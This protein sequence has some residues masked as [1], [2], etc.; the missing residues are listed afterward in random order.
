MPLALI[1][2]LDFKKT[3]TTRD[4]PDANTFFPY[5]DDCGIDIKDISLFLAYNGFD[6][7]CSIKYPGNTFKDGLK[8]LY[9]HL[10]KAR[11]LSDS[12]LQHVQV[13]VVKDILLKVSERSIDSLYSVDGLVQN[14]HLAS[15]D[16]PP[17]KRSKQE[18]KDK[19]KRKTKAGKTSYDEFTCFYGVPKTRKEELAEH[20]IRRHKKGEAEEFWHCIIEN[21]QHI[22][23]EGKSLKKHVQN[24]HF[25]EFY[26]FCKYCPTGSDEK[27][28]IDNHMSKDHKIGVSV[29]CR[30]LGCPKMFAS[31]V[32]RNRHEKYC[33]EG[34][35]F[36]CTNEGCKKSFKREENL[37]RYIGTVHTGEI[38]KVVCKICFKPYQ[39]NTS[40]KAHLKNNQCKP[41]V[42]DEIPEDELKKLKNNS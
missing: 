5:Q 39:S 23:K 2:P 6:H 31:V 19:K 7:Y 36:P 32:F 38:P 20:K 42:L 18:E 29:P 10:T 30:K 4:V 35:V 3:A 28:V 33:N 37:N 1:Q 27:H 11:A 34:K 26:H 9:G 24:L 21:C 12:L 13:S 15:I 25:K 40:F 8:E 17:A 14:L 41:R 22:S 16:E